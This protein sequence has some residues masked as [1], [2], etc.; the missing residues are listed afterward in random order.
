MKNRQNLKQRNME[1]DNNDHLIWSM[2]YF[3]FN[4]INRLKNQIKK[5][6]DS[7]YMVLFVI[8]VGFLNRNDKTYE[9][10]NTMFL[11]FLLFVQ[12][13]GKKLRI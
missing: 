8:K 6:N 7:I 2:P 13:L 3:L 4:Q 1:E 10:C 5:H 9:V 11:L 12:D